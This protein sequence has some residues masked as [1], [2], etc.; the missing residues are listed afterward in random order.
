M[1]WVP[2]ERKNL[3]L[4]QSWCPTTS[5]FLGLA[6]SMGFVIL[7][8]VTIMGNN[9][10]LMHC[11]CQLNIVGPFM[12]VILMSVSTRN[13]CWFSQ[14]LVVSGGINNWPWCLPITFT[15]LK[16]MFFLTSIK[17]RFQRYVTWLYSDLKFR[18]FSRPAENPRISEAQ[19]PSEDFGPT[20]KNVF[21]CEYY[22]LSHIL[23]RYLDSF[24]PSPPPP[25]PLIIAAVGQ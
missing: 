25:P 17:F 21:F 1:V 10:D 19:L 2:L 16:V 9:I 5:P 3:I 14:I 12:T 23:K 6:F 4:I 20:P 11:C 24:D 7:G 18:D 15:A 8:C 22:T 13:F